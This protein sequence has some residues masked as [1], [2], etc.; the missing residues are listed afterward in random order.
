[1]LVARSALVEKHLPL[2]FSWD[3]PSEVLR[4]NSMNIWNGEMISSGYVFYS[5]GIMKLF[6]L[7]N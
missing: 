1:M 5:M 7:I 2:E 4:P 3:E 6:I